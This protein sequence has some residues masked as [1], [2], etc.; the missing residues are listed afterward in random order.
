MKRGLTLPTPQRHL[1][2]TD[3]TPPHIYGDVT[4]NGE[5]DVKELGAAQAREGKKSVLSGV[6]CSLPA[7]VK[8]SHAG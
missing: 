2:Q 1:R 3:Q 7:M 4:V 5:E 8:P 6:P